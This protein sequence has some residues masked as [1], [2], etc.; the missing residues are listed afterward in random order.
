MSVFDITSRKPITEQPA[1]STDRIHKAKT[2]LQ[3]SY[4]RLEQ[5]R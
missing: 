5:L 4:D 1:P 2:I 3:M